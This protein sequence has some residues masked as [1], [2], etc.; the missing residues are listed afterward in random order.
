MRLV[1][2]H[3]NPTLPPKYVL[4]GKDDLI[5]CD[6]D[7]PGVLGVPPNTLIFPFL[8]VAIVCQD[9]HAWKELLELHL[10]VQD[11]RRR[12]D[13]QVLSPDAFVACEMAEQGYGLDRLAG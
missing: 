11:D 9:L 13:N 12:D 10:P 4:V 5:R 6:A 1:Q 7:L 2:D 3:V 8:L